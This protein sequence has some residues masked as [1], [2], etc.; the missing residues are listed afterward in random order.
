MLIVDFYHVPIPISLGFIILALATTLVA[1]FLFPVAA[2]DVIDEAQGKTG[3]IFGSVQVRR[4][5]E[6]EET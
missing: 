4:R 5:G 1:S 3:S 6:N 2:K